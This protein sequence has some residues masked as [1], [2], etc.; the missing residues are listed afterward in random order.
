MDKELAK[1]NLVDKADQKSK[2]DSGLIEEQTLKELQGA[3]DKHKVEELVQ[4]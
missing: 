1:V 3:K 4:Q 2:I